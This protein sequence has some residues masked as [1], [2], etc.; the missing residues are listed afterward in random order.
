MVG[1]RIRL[2][3]LAR[4]MSLDD[5]AD[6]MGGIVSKQAISKYERCLSQPSQ[7]VMVGLAQALEVK[8]SSLWTKPRI[9]VEFIAYRK[10]SGLVKS[11]QDRIRSVITEALENWTELQELMGGSLSFNVPVRSQKINRL[12]DTEAVAEKVRQKWEL[13]VGPIASVTGTMEE[14]NVFVVEVISQEGFDGISA[15]ARDESQKVKAAAVVSRQGISGER[16]R[17]NLVHELG[18]LLLDVPSTIDEE[19]AAFRFGAAFLAPSKLLFKEIGEK[20]SSI[21]LKELILLKKKFGLSMQAIIYRLKDLGVINQSYCRGWFTFINSRGWKKVEP[22]ELAP[23]R[24]QWLQRSVLRAFAEK[25]ITSEKAEQLLG[26]AFECAKQE[27]SSLVRRRSF[28]RLSLQERKRILSE[29]AN[30]YSTSYEPDTDWMEMQGGIGDGSGE[31]HF[32]FGRCAKRRYL[33]HGT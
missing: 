9:G 23:E 16:Q 22:E 17:L 31:E 6:K 30:K 20:R 2:L 12:E 28:M 11:E 14:H 10:G 18:H 3:R 7:K 26:G 33:V 5:L 24:P 1:E 27:S 21:D 25:V 8:T 19:K 29:Q 13:G 32:K 15:V 4:G